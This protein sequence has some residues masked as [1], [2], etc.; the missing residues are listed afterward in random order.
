MSR[1]QVVIYNSTLVVVKKIKSHL[2][3][4]SNENLYSVS[5]LKMVEHYNRKENFTNLNYRHIRYTV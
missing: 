2:W 5:P 3:N 4:V 1:L